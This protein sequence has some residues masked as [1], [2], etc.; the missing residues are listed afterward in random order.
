MRA[1]A[2]VIALLVLCVGARGDDILA[3]PTA[4]M[5]DRG[6]M[7]FA[8]YHVDL[9]APHGGPENIEA[10]V[11]YAGLTDYIE[12]YAQRI[13]I[14]KDVTSVVLNGDLRLMKE[15]PTTPQMVIGCRNIGATPTTNNPPF[16]TINYRARS[17]NQ[18]YYF[19]T[20]RTFYLKDAGQPPFIKLHA[21]VGTSD[22]TLGLQRRHDGLFGGIQA[23]ITPYLGVVALYDG[24]DSITGVAIAPG[25]PGLAIR[26][27]MFSD[28]FYVGVAY[29]WGGMW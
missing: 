6:Q 1:F 2:C 28:S 10:Q 24:A 14:D 7:E 25:P 20:Y 4:N 27:G 11:L 18:S 13:A 12:L 15:T 3:M 22:W 19:C 5:L 17:A 9:P 16:G 8:Y 26:A 21:C 29:R 23:L